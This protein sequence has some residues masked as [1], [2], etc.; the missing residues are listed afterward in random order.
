[1][2]VAAA[3]ELHSIRDL[4]PDPGILIGIGYLVDDG[5]KPDCLHE[6]TV[7]CSDH[8]RCHRQSVLFVL[9]P[10]DNA[11]MAQR[12]LFLGAHGACD[13]LRAK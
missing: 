13:S 11:V 10:A 9:S 7:R 2:E 5:N 12:A 6:T 3:R 1:M 8:V 4:A